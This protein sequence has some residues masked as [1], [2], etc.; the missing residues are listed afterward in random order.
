MAEEVPVPAHNDLSANTKGDIPFV[1]NA[2]EHLSEFTTL[3]SA[4][5]E[6][7]KITII[8]RIIASNHPTLKEDNKAKTSQFYVILVK[9]LVSEYSEGSLSKLVLDESCKALFS[10]TKYVQRDIYTH[11]FDI[12]N[13]LKHLVAKN[14]GK[15]LHVVMGQRYIVYLYLLQRI[16]P[17]TDFKHAV[18]TPIV[19][20]VSWALSS[21]TVRNLADLKVGLFL[22]NFVLQCSQG[23]FCPEVV[24]FLSQTVRCLGSQRNDKTQEYVPNFKIRLETLADESKPGKVA[25]SNLYENGTAKSDVMLALLVTI[26]TSMRAHHDFTGFSGIFHDLIK[27]LNGL[28]I[29]KWH[30]DIQSLATS[31]VSLNE[32]FSQ[33][34]MP[35]LRYQNIKPISIKMYE[36]K[37]SDVFVRERKDKDE[38]KMLKKKIRSET[39]GAIREIRKDNQFIGRVKHREQA[40]KDK[41]RKKKV[42]EIMGFLSREQGEANDLKYRKRH[43]KD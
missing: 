4:Q 30:S 20:A 31:L 6:E 42:N 10:V 28:P 5:N 40:G 17:V 8:K 19:L 29:E 16:Y 18:V 37:F 1:I 21:C 22:C 38:S 14:V 26:R 24:Y 39:K 12:L 41:A 27:S 3:V 34:I 33:K 36:P 9:Y 23:K 15:Q 32:Q 2:P 7:A 35:F 25:I 11:F 43:N 13:S